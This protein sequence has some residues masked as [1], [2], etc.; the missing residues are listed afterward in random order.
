MCYSVIKKFL[1]E[2]YAYTYI[3]LAFLVD[4]EHDDEPR[5][6]P[7]LDRVAGVLS[8]GRGGALLPIR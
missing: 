8:A 3:Y 4:G 1:M 6:R 7:A 2:T 5:E